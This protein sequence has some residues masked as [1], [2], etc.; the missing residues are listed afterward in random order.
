MPSGSSTALRC[1]TA[2]ATAGPWWI[3]S[4]RARPDLDAADRETLLGWRDPV[5]GIFEIRGHDGDA[6]ILLNLLDD[7]G[8][9]RTPTWAG[10]SCGGCP[11]ADS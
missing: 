3:G 5:E 1:S 6:I 11:G 9:E 2:S 7:L 8:T 10:L 4:W